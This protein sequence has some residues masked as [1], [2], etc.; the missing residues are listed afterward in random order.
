M[1]NT[2][3][4]EEEG[5]G[6]SREMEGFLLEVADAVNTTLD[7][8][9]LMHRV[10]ELVKRIINYDVF[11]ILLLNERRQEL[12]IRFQVGHS[13]EVADRIRVKLCW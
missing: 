12:R 7:L 3:Q 8:E 5:Q 2:F 11:A 6:T 4:T 10:A 13:Q 9:T 1:S